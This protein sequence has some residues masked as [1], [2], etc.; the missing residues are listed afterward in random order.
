MTNA[1][2]VYVVLKHKVVLSKSVE[3]ASVTIILLTRQTEGSKQSYFVTSSHDGE[4][5]IFLILDNVPPFVNEVTSLMNVQ[6]LSSSQRHRKSQSNLSEKSVQ[7]IEQSLWLQIL[8]CTLELLEG[9]PRGN[10]L[11][12]PMR[13]WDGILQEGEWKRRMNEE[14]RQV[15]WWRPLRKAGSIPYGRHNIQRTI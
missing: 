1:T 2:A 12:N 15:C 4:Y 10:G 5:V 13:K 11:K 8:L 3:D 7:V 14:L 9:N 6:R